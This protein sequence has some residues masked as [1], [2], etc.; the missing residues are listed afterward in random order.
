MM[1]ELGHASCRAA[2]KSNLKIRN[3]SDDG[4]DKLLWKW[5]KGE[6]TAATDFGAP[7]GSTRYS[8]CLYRGM[9][10][11][12]HGELALL[13]GGTW[14][15]LD[16]KGFKHKD[17][18]GLP[19]GV[20][21]ALLKAGLA[22]KAKVVLKA[23]GPNLPDDLVPIGTSPVVAQLVRADTMACWQTD[24]EAANIVADDAGEF[25]AKR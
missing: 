21:N 13:S 16:A 2:L 6:E 24:Y 11:S 17:A 25:K 7:T 3:S 20:Q 9:L 5:I 10:P 15:S 22:S 19:H 14:T 8:L 4:K 1:H 12:L 18:G 23:K